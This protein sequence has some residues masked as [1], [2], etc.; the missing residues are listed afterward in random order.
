MKWNLVTIVESDVIVYLTGKELKYLVNH[1]C[2]KARH[3]LMFEYL[4]DALFR[5]LIMDANGVE[6]DYPKVI[7]VSINIDEIE[8][9]SKGGR[10][11]EDEMPSVPC[12]NYRRN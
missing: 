2:L 4:G 10:G 5:V 12:I 8:M 9:P 6:V 1:Y 3:R 11:F 7:S